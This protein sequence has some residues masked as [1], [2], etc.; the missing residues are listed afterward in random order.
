MA[1]EK[2]VP[3]N[4]KALKNFNLYVLH[5]TSEVCKWLKFYLSSIEYNPIQIQM[6]KII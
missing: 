4:E 3:R 6:K 5:L 1:D 2:E